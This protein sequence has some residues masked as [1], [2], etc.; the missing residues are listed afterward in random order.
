MK[1]N[2]TLNRTLHRCLSKTVMADKNFCGV[3]GKLADVIM[4]KRQNGAKIGDMLNHLSDKN[5]YVIEY[6]QAMIIRAYQEP[7]H[8]DG[9]GTLQSDAIRAFSNA[10][11]LKCALKQ[12]V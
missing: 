11:Y 9:V 1:N 7:K 5:E 2:T 6:T 12:K 4:T 8:P 3:L 10:E